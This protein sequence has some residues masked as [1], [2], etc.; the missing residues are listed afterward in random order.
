M[1]NRTIAIEQIYQ[2]LN[3]LVE[4]G[5]QP[6][7]ACLFGSVAGGTQHAHSDI[8]LAVWDSRFTGCLTIDYE[9]IKHLLSRY[10]LIEL[11]TF[12]PT[13]DQDSNPWVAE[14]LAHGIPLDMRKVNRKKTVVA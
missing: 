11:H 3:D 9:P 7:Q 10:P 2:L 4:Q 5:Y 1:V 12:S 14:I 8:D 13:D 6:M